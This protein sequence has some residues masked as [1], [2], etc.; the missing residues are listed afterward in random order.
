[1]TLYNISGKPLEKK[2]VD[3]PLL[4]VDPVLVVPA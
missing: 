4:V 1:M 2:I 3:L